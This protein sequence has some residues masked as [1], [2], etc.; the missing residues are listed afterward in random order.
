MEENFCF[1]NSLIARQL[2]VYETH[3]HSRKMAL[4]RYKF[5][6]LERTQRYTIWCDLAK[7]ILYIHDKKK[8]H[9]GSPFQIYVAAADHV[10]KAIKESDDLCMLCKC[11]CRPTL[12][13]RITTYMDH[14]IEQMSQ[15]LRLY[16]D[17]FDC[18]KF[19]DENPHMLKQTIKPP[20][21]SVTWPHNNDDVEPRGSGHP[22]V[23]T[24]NVNRRC[25]QIPWKD[26][27]DDNDDTTTEVHPGRQPPDYDT[28]APPI[29]HPLLH[30]RCKK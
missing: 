2:D 5:C 16:K 23:V 9:F 8:I 11:V 20:Q 29:A 7:K 22:P 15:A 25:D 3:I 19:F 1:Q 17:D 10:W 21:T 6:L 27:C 26:D 28:I 18:K 14:S 4:F 30:R 12:D 24:F 13:E